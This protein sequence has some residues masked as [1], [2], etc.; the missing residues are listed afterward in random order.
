MKILNFFKTC[1]F[2]VLLAFLLIFLIDH[3]AAQSGP[4]SG[5]IEFIWA[6][7]NGT[8]DGKKEIIDFSKRP[9]VKEGD[10]LQIYVQPVTEVYLYLYLVDSQRELYLLFPDTP[11]YYDRNTLEKRKYFIPGEK[12][13][14]TWDNSKGIER[15]YVFASKSRLKELE[16]AT[17]RFIDNPGN[18]KIKAALLDE[19][20]E[21]R[22]SRS[23]TASPTDKP[24]AIAGTIRTRGSEPEI[25][26]KATNTK[27]RE[28]YGKPLRLKHE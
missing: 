17:R 14:F 15:F 27:V 18:G 12:E 16:A 22:K 26:G 21:T 10:K 28:F 20:E 3:A 11:D 7:I 2:S 25:K 1:M 8:P 13:W 6:F 19:M 5:E 9:S 4:N 24:V 23:Q